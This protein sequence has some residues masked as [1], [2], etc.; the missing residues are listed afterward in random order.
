MRY[1]F[2]EYHYT[3]S[4]EYVQK[5]E[6]RKLFEI[7]ADKDLTKEELDAIHQELLVLYSK[8]DKTK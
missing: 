5:N 3:D 7:F 4:L 2:N 8:D 6:V 1:S